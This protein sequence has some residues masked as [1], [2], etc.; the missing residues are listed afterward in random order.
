MSDPI[1]D[2]ASLARAHG[3]EFKDCGG[4]H[5]QISGNGVLVNYYP[6]SKRRSVYVP[7]TGLRE[8]NVGPWNAVRLCLTSGAGKMR[9]TRKP[10]KNQPEVNLTPAVT[11]PAGIRHFYAGDTPP[12]DFPEMVTAASDQLRIEAHELLVAADQNDALN[13]PETA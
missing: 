6:L 7:K 3:L 9:P 4:G 2:T 10:P 8:S 1:K 12:W 11:N 5:V 13:E